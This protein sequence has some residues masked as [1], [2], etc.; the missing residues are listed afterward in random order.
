MNFFYDIVHV[1]H[2]TTDSLINSVT[3]QHSSS[4]DILLSQ[5]L[6]WRKYNKQWIPKCGWRHC[7]PKT[8][9][10]AVVGCYRS[11][12][13]INK[14]NACGSGYVLECRF[15]NFSKITTLASF[16][17]YSWLLVKF[18]VPRGRCLTLTLSVGVIPYQYWH[19][20]YIA[21]N[22]ILWATF[23]LKKVSVYLQPL[24]RNAPRK[25]PNYMK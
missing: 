25:L 10:V 6:L 12:L 16:P 19:K 5:C 13:L 7:T 24:L 23:L 15:T 1:L 20:W 8:M 3:G 18:L 4:Q 2:N 11:W 22:Y 17:S 21:K 14:F 9:N